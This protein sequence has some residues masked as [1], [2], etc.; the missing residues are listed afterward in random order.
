[1]E[2]DPVQVEAVAA[3]RERPLVII[4]GGPGT[5][6]STIVKHIVP[7]LPGPV[8]LL[9]PTGKAAQ[10]LSAMLVDSGSNQNRAAETMDKLLASPVRLAENAG[11]SVLVDET[12]M[13]SMETLSQV[14]RAVRPKKI[15]LV[16]DEDQLAPPGGTPVLPLLLRD[17]GVHVVRLT[18]T[19]R[20]NGQSRLAQAIRAVQ[21]GTPLSALPLP[22][23][24]SAGAEDTSF[25]VRLTQDWRAAAVELCRTLPRPQFLCLTRVTCQAL[26]TLV[27]TTLNQHAQTVCA[28]QGSSGGGSGGTTLRLGDPVM[29]TENYYD[30]ATDM[31]VVANG[32][33]GV[34]AVRNGRVGL[35][36]RTVSPV[37]CRPVEFFDALDMENKQPKTKFDL[38]YA[39][40]THKAQGDQ[41]E[42]VVVVLD[43]DKFLRPSRSLLYTAL[44]R[45]QKQCVLVCARLADADAMIR[46]VPPLRVDLPPLLYQPAPKRGKQEI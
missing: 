26:N 24:G 43:A 9:A 25:L 36:Y 8:L 23:P 41:F 31:L 10:V 30:D 32:C 18:R 29:C 20:Q 2:L 12:S 40:T 13:S 21:A 39:M 6:K 16:G 46:T 44:S 1:M 33:M 27:Q 42:R 4:T 15:I 45:A 37:T 22:P 28:L 38:A 35:A 34:A 7:Q 19:F 14:L 17:P 11:G 5:G 3:A